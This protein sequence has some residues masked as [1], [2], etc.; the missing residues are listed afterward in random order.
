MLDRV[1]ATAVTLSALGIA[2]RRY[3][4]L[5]KAYDR[6][7]PS[8]PSD[9]SFRYAY[10]PLIL[11]ASAAS[12]A[13]YWSQSDGFFHPSSALR[14]IG[15]ALIVAGVAGFEWS[16]RTLGGQYSP[17]FDL[18]VPTVRVTTGPYRWLSHPI[19]VSNVAILLGASLASGS[20]LVIATAMIVSAYYVRAAHTESGLFNEV[21]EASPPRFRAND[22]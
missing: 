8:A 18:R 10:G 1:V 20:V 9:P 17:S 7:R 15:S 11:V 5:N 6:N 21:S 2:G 13:A 3:W 4:S 12:I 16:V 14:L 19:Y 22:R